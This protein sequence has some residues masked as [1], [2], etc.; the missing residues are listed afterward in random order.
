MLDAAEVAKLTIKSD[1]IIECNKIAK[2]LNGGVL[3]KLNIAKGTK[4]PEIKKAIEKASNLITSFK[5]VMKIPICGNCGF[6]D[7]KLVEK[8]PQCKSPYIL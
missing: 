6:K 5:P 3:T 4:I 7:E 2:L 8:C 1:K